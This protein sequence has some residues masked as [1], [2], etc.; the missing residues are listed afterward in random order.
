M[1]YIVA[2]LLKESINTLWNY[3]VSSLQQQLNRNSEIHLFVCNNDLGAKRGKKS[4]LQITMAGCLCSLAVSLRAWWISN[5][6]SQFAESCSG[7]FQIPCGYG[8]IIKEQSF[9]SRR[10]F[11]HLFVYFF[12]SVNGGPGSEVHYCNFYFISI[13]F[14][15]AFHLFGNV[16]KNTSPKALFAVIESNNCQMCFV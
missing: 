9:L 4:G 1:Q 8:G 13:Y 14:T 5:Q 11:I 3:D 7:C 16:S 15:S 6:H 12:A 10:G 2:N